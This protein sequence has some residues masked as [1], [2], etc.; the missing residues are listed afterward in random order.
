[1]AQDSASKL[2]PDE[3]HI[4]TGL[5]GGFFIYEAEGDEEIYFAEQNV[6]ELFGCK[7]IAEFREHVG[8]SFRGMV[9]PDDLDRIQNDIQAQ[10]FTSEKYHDYV[11]YR[12]VTKQ[13]KVR[14]VE[15][16][17]HLIHGEDGKKFFYVY[18]VDV[19]ADEYY[20]RDNNSFA[21]AEIMAMHQHI[22]QLT[23]LMNMPSFYGKAQD[24]ITDESVR[25]KKK[26]TF[27]H[28]D[29]LNFKMFNEN[30]GFERGDDLLCRFAYTLR[31]IFSDSLVARFSN[32]H[33]VVC[34]TDD[35][36]IERAQKVHETM[37]NILESI[38]V[39]VK[40]GVFELDDSCEEVG[41]A[42]DHARLACNTV[43]RRYD[44]VY[45]IYDDDF[46]EKLRIKQYVIDTIDDAI[47]KEFIKVFYQPV[48]RV[49]TGRI[50]GYEALARW[51]DPKMGTLSPSQFIPTLEEY[52]LIHKLD[53]FVFKKVCEDLHALYT[54][55]EPVEPVSVNLSQ[56]DFEMI[57]VFEQ[58]E[59]YRSLYGVPRNYIDL[60]ITESALNADFE[61]LQQEIKRFRDAGYHI[62]IDDFGSGYS[63]LNNLLNYDSDVLKLDLEFLRTLD[64]NPNAAGLIR[65]I[66]EGAKQMGMQPLQEGVETEEHLEFLRSIGCE[67]VQGYYFAKPMAI[68]ESRIATRAKGLEW[69]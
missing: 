34:T 51:I 40:A 18:I 25:N 36:A 11:R 5:P 50:C 31:S 14:Y 67:R 17:G 28:F 44:M 48:I 62:W 24:L 30:Y 10:T 37:V 16:F 21:E 8:N 52:R 64:R 56:I 46:Y 23:G 47:E 35:D 12:I 49:A 38:H 33:F 57:D 13:G 55:G 69:E 63:S 43:K 54:L 22:D 19:D 15:D 58:A 53:C 45:A 60:E 39:E 41:L 1:M 6:I 32:D 59:H 61:H 65:H 4:P 68:D 27:L 9:H 3:N 66:V 7:T 26:I 42:C 2:A 29:I 20:N